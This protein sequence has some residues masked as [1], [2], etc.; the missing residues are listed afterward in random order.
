MFSF[1]SDFSSP[2]ALLFP[3]LLISLGWGVTNPLLTFHSRVS[4]SS[5]LSSLSSFRSPVFLFSFVFNQL[6]SF[7]FVCLLSQPNVPISLAVPL[8]NSL[9]SV[10]TLLTEQTAS[11]QERREV[12]NAR[13]IAGLTLMIAGIAIATSP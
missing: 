2:L 13:G 12:L 6:C 7:L 10:F 5:S 1:S 9:T 11:Q 8:T 3:C 4:S